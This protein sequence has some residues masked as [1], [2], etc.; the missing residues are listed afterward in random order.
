MPNTVSGEKKPRAKFFEPSFD[1]TVGRILVEKKY[2]SEGEL[3]NYKKACAA[4]KKRLGTI[5]LEN[6]IVSRRDLY[7]IILSQMKN[8][9]L[10]TVLVEEKFI[11][12][13]ELTRV[14]LIKKGNLR[15]LGRY[16][17]TS[18]ILSEQNFAQALAKSF[19]LAY[20]A[21]A[22]LETVK[23]LPENIDP[24]FL[25]TFLTAVT[26]YSQKNK[27]IEFAVCDPS[28]IADILNS[29]AFA[30]YRVSFVITSFG[31][32]MKSLENICP[33]NA[34]SVP[35]D[36]FSE[37]EVSEQLEE[38]K[39]VRSFKKPSNFPQKVLD[40]IGDNK[41]SLIRPLFEI[42]YDSARAGASEI[43]F[44]AFSDNIRIFVKINGRFFHLDHSIKAENYEYIVAK[45]KYLGK[46]DYEEDRIFQVS[47]F[48]IHLSSLRLF[49]NALTVPALFGENM[50]LKILSLNGFPRPLESYFK[51][52]KNYCAKIR[53]ALSRKS[54]LI[55]LSSP[56]SFG[57][58]KFYYTI[59]SEAVKLNPDKKIVSIEKDLICPID[60]VSQVEYSLVNEPSLKM[61]HETAI[62]LGAEIIATS[63]PHEAGAF[64]YVQRSLATGALVILIMHEPSAGAVMDK[65]SQSKGAGEL[66]SSLALIAAAKNVDFICNFCREED[67]DESVR[68][69]C[70]VY[71]GRG[72]P[73]CYMTGVGVQSFI[74]ELLSADEKTREA[75]VESLKPKSKSKGPAPE[76]D[77]FDLLV[78]ELGREGIIF[79]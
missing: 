17:I 56:D 59:L 30:S 74:F 14:F 52:Q 68:R 49:V 6:N 57:L 15:K 60:C 32:I 8:K 65:M 66:F 23:M 11:S 64:E 79:K 70:K 62:N 54:G 41:N 76:Y 72:C 1:D 10:P 55:V 34:R 18:G 36:E 27:E 29:S 40:I 37:I 53:E 7:S 77:K 12:F 39:N 51:Y 63:V 42:L 47:N 2:L 73:K 61:V 5:L 13:D 46:L 75:L 71:H 22:K 44:E 50:V 16:L 19:D 33:K 35:I 48:A 20:I 9:E 24:S 3:Q 69:A 25:T 21:P 67:F 78:N 45:V 43:H 4:Q 31:A 26:K 58:T 38:L 28:N